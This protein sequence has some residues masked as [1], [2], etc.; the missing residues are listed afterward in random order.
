MSAEIGH[1]QGPEKSKKTK[2]CIYFEID[3]DTLTGGLQLCIGDDTGGYRIAGPKYSGNSK[4]LQRHEI[5]AYD[6]QKIRE[7]LDT[8]FPRQSLS[9]GG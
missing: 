1:A 5:D 4:R 2:K 9:E 8:A 3:K 6:A 7:H